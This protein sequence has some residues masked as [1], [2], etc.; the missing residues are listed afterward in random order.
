MKDQLDDIDWVGLGGKALAA[1]GILVATWIVA[2]VISWAIAK[3]TG[4]VPVLQK[5]GADGASIGSS[6][7]SIASMLVWLF[8]LTAVLQLFGLTQVLEPIQ[9]LLSGVLG[10][11]PRLIGAV[12]VF[13]LGAL[14]AKIV[15]QLVETALGA[16]PFDKWLGK[17]GAGKVTGAPEPATYGA[18]GVAVESGNSVQTS[19]L[20]ALV[21]Y[22]MIMIVVAIAALQVL[23]ISSISDPA[24]QML[25]T[26]LDA[27]PHIIAAALLL[28]I[29]VLI[30]RFAGDLLR[31]LLDGLGTDRA[32]REMEVLPE[33][34]TAT[35][36]ITKVAQVAIVLFFG[37]MAAQL[38][39]FPQITVFISEVLT[40]GGKV[41]FGAAIIAAG[42]FIATLLAKLTSGTAS[43][44]IKYATLVLFAAIGLKFMGLADSIINLGF[45]A[46]VV[47]AAAAAALAF[48]LGGREAAARQLASLQGNGNGARRSDPLDPSSGI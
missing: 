9:S 47:G 5:A 3:A 44:V 43:Q 24:Q 20:I 21:L 2:K 28:G 13:V 29:G 40:L 23:G 11:L 26:I 34:K 19:K 48:G 27:I 12:F 41:V 42:Y 6:L 17:A 25:N 10:F 31:Q 8:G 4:K 45:G 46:L 32:L 38:L 37:V 18:T 39:Q 36:A 1:L 14:V 16:L 30:A 33:G 35:P 22:S 15:R 7:G